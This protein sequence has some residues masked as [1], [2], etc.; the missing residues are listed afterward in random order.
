MKELLLKLSKGIK[1]SSILKKDLQII[2]EL[3]SIGAIKYKDGLVK[4]NSSYKIGKLDISR[5]GLGFVEV[6]GENIKDLLVES[7][8]L[9]KAQ[10]GDIVLVKKIRKK[11]G[12]PGSTIEKIIQKEFAT[13]VVYLTKHKGKIE[14][15]N[16]KTELPVNIAAKQKELKQLPPNTVLK[17][18]NYTEEVVDVLGI[19]DD[20]SVDEKISL[21]LFDKSSEFTKQSETE[22]IS[23]GTTVDKS[24]YPKRRDLTS[25]PFCTI[26]PDSAKDFDDAIYYDKQKNELY[27]AIADVSEYVSQYSSIDKEAKNRGFTIYFPHKSI[28][29]LPRNLSENICSLQPNV[30]RLSF[31]FKIRFNDNLDVI[32]EELFEGV[33]NSKRRFTYT[34]VDHYLHKDAKHI[35]LKDALV[36]KWLLPLYKLTRELRERRLKIGY[37]FRSDDISMILEDHKLVRTIIDHYTPSHSLI[38]ECMLLANKAAAKAISYGI[39]RNHTEPSLERITELFSDLASIGIDI[40]LNRNLHESVVKAQQQADMLGIRAEVDKMIIKAQRQAF[41]G[42]TNLG[43]FGLGF[44]DYTHFTS[45]IRRYSDLI[46]HR[47]LKSQLAQDKKQKE[48]LLENIEATTISINT[49]E[50]ENQKV[51]WDFMD[52]K[53]ARWAAEHLEEE[54]DAIIVDNTG[55]NMIAKIETPDIQG[56][57]VFMNPK[58][59]ELYEKIRVRIIDVNIATTK[60]KVK[61]V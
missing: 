9:N 43:H 2:D 36:L 6:Y 31:V 55:T 17:I 58:S 26:D 52:R 11:H 53:Y 14:A 45:P 10:K 20:P 19:L 46:L 33:I 4:L 34:E 41:Y 44:E 40:K 49:L 27:V 56:V 22:A 30:D 37:D 29:M 59:V 32:D 13:S 8:D 16:I 18:N 3:K 15:L 61:L 39:F 28:P 21:A 5:Q 24:M 7:D 35:P 42:P 38:E 1:E 57:R 47:L 60:I 51:A 23:F 50:R 12:R 54:F 25:L 48:Y